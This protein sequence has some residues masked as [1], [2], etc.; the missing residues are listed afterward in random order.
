[1]DVSPAALVRTLRAELGEVPVLRAAIERWAHAHDVPAAAIEPMWLMLDELI[2]NIVTHGYGRQASG[3]TVEV[4]LE[5]D[6][7]AL[8]A[9]VRDTAPA[10]DPLSIGTPDMQAPVESRPIGGLGVHLV[11]RLAH[12]ISYRRV[13]GGN[14]LR[15][16]RRLPGSPPA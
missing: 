12:D 16:V 2:T 6:G 5:T 4:R 9:L 13:D 11:R 15:V 14:E 3:G 10:F 8:T 7:R 1:M